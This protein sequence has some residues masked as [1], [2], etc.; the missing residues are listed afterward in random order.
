[1]DRIE[2]NA[3]P[4][5]ETIKEWYRKYTSSSLAWALQNYTDK[6]Q[7]NQNKTVYVKETSMNSNSKGVVRTWFHI[8]P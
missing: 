1:M 3:K 4:N 7:L 6:R 5:A 2:E 8:A